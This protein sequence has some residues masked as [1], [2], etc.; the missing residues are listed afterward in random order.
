M[1]Y[2]SLNLISEEL[3]NFYKRTFLILRSYWKQL[4]VASFSAALHAI[5]SGM[6]VWIAGPLMM[7]L[8]QVENLPLP[9][10]PTENVQKVSSPENSVT[11]DDQLASVADNIRETM[12]SWVNN[13]VA[14]DDRQTMLINFSWLI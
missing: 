8:F 9:Q 13:I 11:I 14:A 1:P 3:L 6:M 10:T 2:L 7:T 12:K 4:A 5:F